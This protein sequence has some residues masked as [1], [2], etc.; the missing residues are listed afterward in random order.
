MNRYDTI[1]KLIPLKR[2]DYALAEIN[3]RRY[4][5]SKVFRGLFDQGTQGGWHMFTNQANMEAVHT[6]LHTYLVSAD[7]IIDFT[8]AGLLNQRRNSDTY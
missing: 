8:A 3:L 1:I 6:S 4:Q 2:L 7:D 5:S